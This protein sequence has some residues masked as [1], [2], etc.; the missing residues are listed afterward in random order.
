MTNDPIA[1]RSSNGRYLTGIPMASYDFG[2]WNYSTW[3]G[4]W[5]R[6]T[7]EMVPGERWTDR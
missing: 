2:L 1:L 5:Q 7:V 3:V 4:A 6:F